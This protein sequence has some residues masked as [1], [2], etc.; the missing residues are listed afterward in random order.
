M[1][2]L[3]TE[4]IRELQRELGVVADG[5]IGPKTRAAANKLLMESSSIAAAQ[6]NAE[7]YSDVINS[8]G[9]VFGTDYQI[10]DDES[11]DGDDDPV[12]EPGGE[13]VTG[14]PKILFNSNGDFFSVDNPEQE[15]AA[16]NAGFVLSTAPEPQGGGFD[17]DGLNNILGQY[18]T[19]SQVQE[20][21]RTGP[22]TF[23]QAKGL[24]PY[25]DDR[26]V[27]LFLN[28]Y[29][30]SGNERLA[31]AEMRADPIM[32]EIYPGIKRDDG[33]LRMTEQEY[34][35]AVDNM[36]ASVRKFNLNP[37][38][39]NDDIVQAIGGDVSPLEF[40]Q[41]LD[42]GYEGVVNN[43]PQVKQA[44]LDNFGI[45][46][47]DES[48]FAMFVSPNVATKILEGQIRAS[49]V[50]G[51]AEAAGFG[52][53]TAQVAQS[54]TAQG[55]TQEGARKGFGEAALSLPGIQTAALSQGR[56]NIGV[57]EYVEATQLG[58]AQ[59]LRE[60]QNVINQNRAESAA[61]LG[62]ATNRAGQV[63]GLIEQ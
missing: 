59:Q 34:V 58:D 17:L 57:A 18:A 9:L 40:S 37:N 39:F 38:E 10:P 30:E 2:G 4:E 27:R 13:V 21:V 63:T 36:K 19:Q 48:I 60:L 23:E 47:P 33:S 41:R 1:E 15:Q 53:I 56:D 62:A 26:L 20:T 61:I 16:R 35:A 52:S 46:L 43:I 28:K 11:D 29:A 42:A 50:I 45:D 51:E 6:F 31:L 44:Y 32:V 7:K 5:I 14:Y 24:Y 8:D 49:Q 25:L 3:T 12:E 55:L 54:L 22:S